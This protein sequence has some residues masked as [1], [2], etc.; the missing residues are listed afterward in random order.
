MMLKLTSWR[1]NVERPNAAGA[2]K[3]YVQTITIT[4]TKYLIVDIQ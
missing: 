2:Y 1:R 4:S 3:K